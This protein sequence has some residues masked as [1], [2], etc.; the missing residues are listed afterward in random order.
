[1]RRVAIARFDAATLGIDS[2]HTVES[3][4]NKVS[5]L[6]DEKSYTTAY[7]SGEDCDIPF[8]VF[9]RDQLILLRIRPKTKRWRNMPDIP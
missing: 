4:G 9:G 5:L 2:R 8:Q 6:I 3:G 1:M 7:G